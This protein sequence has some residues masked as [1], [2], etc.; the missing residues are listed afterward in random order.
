MKTNGEEDSPLGCIPLYSSCPSTSVTST[1]PNK[2][3][4]GNFVGNSV[5]GQP[6]SDK[7]IHGSYNF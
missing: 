3:L 6:N 2:Q 1:Q 4:T 5:L 7:I